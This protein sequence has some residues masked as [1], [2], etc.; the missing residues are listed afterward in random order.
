M[1]YGS[2]FTMHRHASVQHKPCLHPALC[3]WVATG[4]KKSRVRN[5]SASGV[6]MLETSYCKLHVPLGAMAK[7]SAL[8]TQNQ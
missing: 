5:A 2:A 7:R 1:A 8:A 6:S 4:N 3:N